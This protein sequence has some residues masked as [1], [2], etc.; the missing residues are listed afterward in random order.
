MLKIIGYKRETVIFLVKEA[1]HFRILCDLI[2]FF[3]LLSYGFFLTVDKILAF[4]LL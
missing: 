4:R 2:L 1:Q 3:K